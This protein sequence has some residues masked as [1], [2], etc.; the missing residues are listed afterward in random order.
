MPEDAPLAAPPAEAAAKPAPAGVLANAPLPQARP[1]P[2]AALGF[3]GPEQPAP[4]NPALAA[5]ATVARLTPAPGI[6]LPQARPTGSTAV[7]ALAPTPA[8]PIP[9]LPIASPQPPST[10]TP[11]TAPTPVGRALLPPVPSTTASVAPTQ[12]GSLG[13]SARVGAGSEALATFTSPLEVAASA[14]MLDGS[15]TTRTKRFAQLERPSFESIPALITTPTQTLAKGF[16]A[17]APYGAMRT[18]RF[19]GRAVAVLAVVVTGN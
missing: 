15:V 12:G 2:P 17:A 8:A 5:P 14:D 7:A 3:A 16:D 13:R 6:P 10:A 1:V 11:P 9:P 18:D 19:S 4:I